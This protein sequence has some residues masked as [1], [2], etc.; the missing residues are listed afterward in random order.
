MRNGCVPQKLMNVDD[1]AASFPDGIELPSELRAL[2]DW[3]SES[4]Y[5]ISGYFKIEEHD[6]GCRPES[7]VEL[8]GV[9]R[10]PLR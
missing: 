6:D 10:R 4:G 2:C 1:L 8:I 9:P 3:L 5:P 7:L